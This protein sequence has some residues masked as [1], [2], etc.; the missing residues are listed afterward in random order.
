MRTYWMAKTR[1]FRS[2]MD[3][4]GITI[5]HKD[6]PYPYEFAEI[7]RSHNLTN[8]SYG[9]DGDFRIL[10]FTTMCK[11]LKLKPPLWV[12]PFP[13]CHLLLNC[14]KLKI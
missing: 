13:L 4:E 3:P 9:K 6:L 14:F 5:F 1:L 2:L 11:M 8:W 10:K 12:K 7:C